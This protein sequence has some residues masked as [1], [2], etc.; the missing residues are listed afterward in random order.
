[1]ID[2]GSMQYTATPA[3]LGSISITSSNYT[4]LS[5]ATLTITFLPDTSYTMVEIITPTDIQIST[6][7]VARSCAS[8]QPALSS[9]SYAN[10]NLT[11]SSSN[12]LTG[13]TTLT[14]SGSLMPGSFSPTGKFQVYTYYNGW[15]VESSTGLLTL[16][17]NATAEFTAK[18]LSMSSSMNSQNSSLTL[19]LTLPSGSPTGT[20]AVDVPSPVAINS[21]LACTINGVTVTC[22]VSSRR[23]S[24]PIN[25]TTNLVNTVVI[26]TLGNPPTLQPT[27]STLNVSLS[28]SLGR[29]S[30][31]SSVSVIQ[32][33][34]PIPL[35]AATLTTGIGFYG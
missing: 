2:S 9:C 28:D 18:S 13:S 24:M 29:A 21:N 20:L 10:N 3:T 33:T 32:N 16:T 11:F 17:M 23:V 19:Q 27:S 22:G 31:F 30:L 7:Q 14:W 5:V 6:D 35:T 1:M 12:A 34:Q 4:V 8:N 26:S 25:P 15:L